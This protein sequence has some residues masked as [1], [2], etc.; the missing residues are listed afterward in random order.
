[1]VESCNPSI[2]RHNE[3]TKQATA[4]TS[5]ERA[6]RDLYKYRYKMGKYQENFGNTKADRERQYKFENKR[7][8]A[9]NIDT[10]QTRLWKDE[11]NG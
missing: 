6:A 8:K 5:S 9:E 11:H 2:R 7:N 3:N 4:F 10:F 1:M